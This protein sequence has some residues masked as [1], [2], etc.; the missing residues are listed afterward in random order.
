MFEA[1]YI[2]DLNQ[3]YTGVYDA[4]NATKTTTE[5]LIKFYSTFDRYRDDTYA[6]L[7]Q[8]ISPSVRNGTYKIF[9]RDGEI[10]GFMN[11]SFVNNAVL[12]KFLQ[13]GHMGTLD[14]Q[15]G[16]NMVWIDALSKHSIQHMANWLKNYTVNLLGLNVRVY[17]LKINGENIRA[18]VKMRTKQSWRSDV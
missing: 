5:R 10:Y 18:K 4:G 12:R 3:Q 15:T 8:H 17:W 6:E 9:Q 16:L 1:T 11:W 13:T 2:K 14:W 7:Y